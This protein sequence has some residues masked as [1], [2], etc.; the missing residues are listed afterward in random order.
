MCS[1][2]LPFSKFTQ[3]CQMVI[4][5]YC[6]HKNDK[7]LSFSKIN[8]IVIQLITLKLKRK[9]NLRYFRHIIL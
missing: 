4:W 3:V 2:E 5:C 8:C 6:K 9:W 7:Y 1:T